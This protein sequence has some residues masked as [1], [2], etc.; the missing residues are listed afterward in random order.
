M[1]QWEYSQTGVGMKLWNDPE[2]D[3]QTRGI[4]IR[5]DSMVEVSFWPESGSTRRWNRLFYLG[6]ETGWIGM[7]EFLESSGNR[8]VRVPKVGDG[9]W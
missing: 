3:R 2:T 6:S 9:V 4:C 8:S 7:G 1:T 5:V